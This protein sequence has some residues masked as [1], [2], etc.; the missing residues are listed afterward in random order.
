MAWR[1]TERIHGLFT[2]CLRPTTTFSRQ[3]PA[4][5]QIRPILSPQAQSEIKA[6]SRFNARNLAMTESPT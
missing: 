4:A 2:D 3:S 6:E 1:G 5:S